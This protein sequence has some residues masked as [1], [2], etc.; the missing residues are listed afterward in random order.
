MMM[1]DSSIIAT[2]SR[3]D[4]FDEFKKLPLDLKIMLAKSRIEEWYEHFDGKVYI[5]LSGGKD[6]TVLSDLVWSIYPDVPAL[7]SNTGLEY[8]EIVAFVKKLKAEGRPIII[9]RPKKT[10][11]QSIQED[12]FPLVSKK[13]SE[14]VSRFY[15]PLPSNEATRNLYLTGYRKDGVYVAGSKLPEKW[16]P[17]INAPFKVTS[18]CCDSLKKEP[19]RRF[20]RETGLV[21][22]V[23]IMAS[24]GG[25][26]ATMD[27][28][29]A[30]D[31][32]EP[33][34][35]PML[36]WSESDVWQ[37]IRENDIEYSEI[38]D[39]RFVDGVRVAGEKRTGCM[40]CAYGAHLEEGENRFQRM[41]ISH[42]KQW[43]YAINKLEMGEAL[44]F[45]G[46][47]YHPSSNALNRDM[48]TE[49]D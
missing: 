13:V 32:K 28:C 9:T 25:R 26:R 40:F 31:Q 42:P 19:F 45:I 27:T 48:F 33:M 35:R 15:N 43:N 36:F 14:M 22:Y 20:N 47:E 8:P 12:G 37:Y 44:D 34:S 1:D 11:R 21:P 2:D 41:A 6:S 39:D 46:V 24:E 18:K 17:L 23:G 30:F 29:N 49:E 16:K 5:A 4:K 10:F 3:K 38:Y 7:F